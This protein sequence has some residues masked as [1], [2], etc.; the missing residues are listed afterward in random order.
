M[1]VGAKVRR[2]VSLLLAFSLFGCQGQTIVN[3]KEVIATTESTEIDLKKKPIID[4]M[5]QMLCKQTSSPELAS[6]SENLTT[7]RAELDSKEADDLLFPLT[8]LFED[9]QLFKQ[10]VT[11]S[12]SHWEKLSSGT[13]G[14]RKNVTQAHLKWFITWLQNI[15]NEFEGEIDTLIESF[16]SPV[17]RRLI[18]SH[19]RNTLVF[20]QTIQSKKNDTSDTS[21]TKEIKTEW[22]KKVYQLGDFALTSLKK[23]NVRSWVEQNGKTAIKLLRDQKQGYPV[24]QAL[25]SGYPNAKGPLVLKE[26]N[27]IIQANHGKKEGLDFD[28][29]VTVAQ[30]LLFNE[31]WTLPEVEVLLLRLMPPAYVLAE[32][33]LPQTFSPMRSLLQELLNLEEQKVVTPLLSAT[34]IL[35]KDH[36]KYIPPLI[37]VANDQDVLTTL[38]YEWKY[39]KLKHVIQNLGLWSLVS[40]TVLSWLDQKKIFAR[41]LST[42]SSMPPVL[43]PEILMPDNS[44]TT[45]I[46]WPLLDKYL[47]RL[48]AA[49]QETLAFLKAVQKASGYKKL[50]WQI[51]DSAL[52]ALV[53]PSFKELEQ[54]LEMMAQLI[55]ED[56]TQD[57]AITHD[58][59]LTPVPT[60]PVVYPSILTNV[61]GGHLL[62]ADRKSMLALLKM[63]PLGPYVKN[64][65]SYVDYKLTIR[66]L[67]KKN[68][69]WDGIKNKK[70]F[71]YE[72]IKAQRETYLKTIPL[73][74]EAFT[75]LLFM[76]EEPNKKSFKSDEALFYLASLGS[77]VIDY[78][79]EVGDPK[80][81]MAEVTRPKLGLK[82]QQELNDNKLISRH[83]FPD[84]GAPLGRVMQ[85]LES[86]SRYD[87]HHLL[88]DDVILGLRKSLKLLAGDKIENKEWAQKSAAYLGTFVNKRAVKKVA[89]DHFLSKY[90][91]SLDENYYNEKT[92]LYTHL[93]R[94]NAVLVGQ[95]EMSSIE[96]LESIVL[97]GSYPFNYQGKDISF[98]I[99]LGFV[100]YSSTK[101]MDHIWQN[102]ALWS[103]SWVKSLLSDLD[104]AGSLILSPFN[105]ISVKGTKLLMAQ[106]LENSASVELLTVPDSDLNGHSVLDLARPV[107]EKISLFDTK[108]YT[109][110]K[111]LRLLT[112]FVETGF[113]R[114]MRP[115]IH[116]LNETNGLSDVIYHMGQYLETYKDQKNFDD[117]DRLITHFHW[118]SFFVPMVHGLNRLDLLDEKQ[119]AYV[120][121]GAVVA[122]AVGIN[123]NDI[124]GLRPERIL[125]AFLNKLQLKENGTYEFMENLRKGVWKLRSKKGYMRGEVFDLEGL[126]I[127]RLLRKI[128][129]S[130]KESMTPTLKWGLALLLQP[131]LHSDTTSMSVEKRRE[132]KEQSYFDG[133]LTL[134]KF[135]STFVK[136]V[137]S[138]VDSM[139]Q[140]P[141]WF[142]SCDL[143]P[144]E[145]FLNQR[146]AKWVALSKQLAATR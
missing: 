22:Q 134:G 56:K 136:K 72:T 115:K 121:D 82:F 93:D 113:F 51:F 80:H 142:K 49:K 103:K 124:Y 65:E 30:G 47:A 89:H 13:L 61:A 46:P 55:A 4:L 29:L 87:R 143:Q 48:G 112:D 75:Y 132:I 23:T 59:K 76:S 102:Y 11:Y 10:V 5:L 91:K 119:W 37:K 107:V 118:N 63:E 15:F 78:A 7:L 36:A 52:A 97:L 35:M 20:I 31:K 54:P 60:K 1:F 104:T 123:Y 62:E 145:C 9:S 94:N 130:D 96:M 12:Q 6:F 114:W 141:K 127:L 53:K 146:M 70:K 101:V 79:N 33:L 16:K 41:L 34:R 92:S 69:K 86:S 64:I 84:W 105:V 26:A 120:L 138:S 3:P 131:L 95:S 21:Q 17:K 83:N 108:E 125:T 74:T 137:I 42:L 67:F 38:S 99:N 68:K 45:G 57:L 129:E 77:Q 98:K 40:D 66:K 90:L 27:Q 122:S 14:V 85:K 126:G 135:L 8:I 109:K 144:V 32:P 88:V 39:G 58:F 44:I 111:R 106:L 24:L 139:E 133:Y 25:L 81:S 19:I 73:I 71:L 100:E 140:L 116:Y 50:A 128:W 2:V 43:A 110:F 18:L 28:K 117:L